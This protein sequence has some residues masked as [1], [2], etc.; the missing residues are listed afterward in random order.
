MDQLHALRDQLLHFNRRINLISREDEAHLWTHHIVHCLALA[1]RPFP[2]GSVVVDWGTGGGLPALP[3][4]ICFPAVEV[5]AVDAVGK[6][7]RAVRAMGRRLG[8][9]NLHSWHGRAEQW[10][11]QAHYSVSRATA[12]LATLWRWHRRAL[13]DESPPSADTTAWRPGLLCLKGGDLRGEIADLR[14]VAAAL[15]IIQHPLQPVLQHPFFAEKMLLEV[16][17]EQKAPPA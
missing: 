12:P 11:G 17:S 7:V 16:R 13:L 9:D 14:A 1:A 2:A 15:T 10:P 6:K 4:A 3:L 5:H 8:L